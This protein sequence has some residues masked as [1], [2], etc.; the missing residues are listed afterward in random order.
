MKKSAVSFPCGSIMLEGVYYIP[1][2]DA[3]FPAVIL[4]HPHPLYGGSMANNVI[5]AAAS[6]LVD[7][8]IITFTFNF[9]GVGG[10]QGVYGDGI[11]EQKDVVAAIDW[12]GA[13]PEV[14]A[15]RIGLMG[16]SFGALVASPV[17]CN[18]VR[19][20]AMALVSP[21]L[22]D[23]QLL[24]LKECDKPKIVICGTEDVVVSTQRAE[25]INR[26]LAEPKQFKLI[27]GA[28]HFWQGYE[29]AMAD[30]AAAFFQ[31]AI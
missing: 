9:R 6:I 5:M 17:A 15:G 18:D 13:Q 8:S 12:L 22:E 7:M 26:E 10:S 11:E 14:D 24:K 23:E 20:K 16:Y 21:P 2:G 29:V 25:L 31:R 19:V 1:D 27:P 28:D 4:C 30:K 3:V